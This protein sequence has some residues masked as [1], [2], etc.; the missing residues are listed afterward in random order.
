MMLKKF[1][2]IF[3]L[4]IAAGTPAFAAPKEYRTFD[5][6][7]ASRAADG[8]VVFFFGADWSRRQKEIYANVW[9]NKTVRDA[10]GNAALLTI[11]IYQD[12]SP[13]QK[14]VAKKRLAGSSFP[15]A[16][17]YPCIYFCDGNGYCYAK[18]PESELAG[19]PEN[20]AKK[21]A[22][23]IALFREQRKL[24]SAGKKASGTERAEFFGKASSMDGIAPPQNAEK[25]IAAADPDQKTPYRK[26]LKYDVYKLITDETL[27]RPEKGGTPNISVDEACA[28]VEALTK[29]ETYLP[30]QKQELLAAAAAHIR[31]HDK[32]DPRFKKYL[33]EIIKIDP[34]SLYGF[35]AEESLRIWG[36]EKSSG[37]SPA[38]K[39]KKKR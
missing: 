35:Y 12:P 25:I 26:R 2:P 18:I 31:R 17:G 32:N 22:A 23:K 24:V 28:R 37:N 29:D 6:A 21:A 39:K 9:K 10:C 27:A 14:E 7:R 4:A 13:K 5:D 16:S 30:F 11:P 20:V 34:K 38:Q 15:R 36:S 8:I 19:T 1:L 33:R 3:L